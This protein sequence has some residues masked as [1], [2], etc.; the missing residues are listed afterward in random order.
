MSENKS[1]AGHTEQAEAVAPG[2]QEPIHPERSPVTTVAELETLDGAEIL[3]G[4]MDGYRGE[5]APGDNR[6]K[7][8]WHGYSNAMRDRASGPPDP[9][10]IALARDMRRHGYF[11]K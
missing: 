1:L 10:G 5:P 4:F 3:E 8:Y 7:A 11:G 9:A 6:S 2:R